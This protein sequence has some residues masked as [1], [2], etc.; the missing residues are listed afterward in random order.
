[1]L[2]AQEIRCTA[3][4]VRYDARMQYQPQPS[5]QRG[6]PMKT[7]KQTENH[8]LTEAQLNTVD[9]AAMSREERLQWYIDRQ[10]AFRNGE[11]WRNIPKPGG[12]GPEYTPWRRG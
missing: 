12:E 6:N 10:T 2:L 11:D 5:T 7:A 4:A 3:R 9:G 8:V 1:L